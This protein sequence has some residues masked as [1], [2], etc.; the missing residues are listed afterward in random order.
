MHMPKR[1]RDMTVPA[2]WLERGKDV[3]KLLGPELIPLR[4]GVIRSQQRWGMIQM[5]WPAKAFVAINAGLTFVP[6]GH[7]VP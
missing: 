3:R 1:F 6:V 7:N 2:D 4:R 5:L